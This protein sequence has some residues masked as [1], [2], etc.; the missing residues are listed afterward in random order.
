MINCQPSGSAAVIARRTLHDAGP[1][2]QPTAMAL[3]CAH[4]T[5]QVAASTGDHAR[6]SNVV[7]AKYASSLHVTYNRTGTDAAAVIVLLP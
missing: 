1:V 7:P 5:D 4:Q 2:H 6:D 3:M